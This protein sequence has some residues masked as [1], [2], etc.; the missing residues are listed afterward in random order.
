MECTELKLMPAGLHPLW[1]AV[2]QGPCRLQFL[3][4]A[5][6]PWLLGSSSIFKA[7]SG[8]SGTFLSQITQTFFSYSLK[9]P[10]NHIEPTRT[11]HTDISVLR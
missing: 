4:A 2:E 7:S 9:D 11:I 3:F 1:E 6:S 8:W 10:H 5:H